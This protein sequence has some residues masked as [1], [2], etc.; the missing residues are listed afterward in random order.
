MIFQK[1]Q[2]TINKGGSRYI[3]S[4]AP[5]ILIFLIFFYLLLD[6]VGVSFPPRLTDYTRHQQCL[7][8]LTLK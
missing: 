3:K 7:L 2:A 8:S 6:G 1:S 5:F 4:I